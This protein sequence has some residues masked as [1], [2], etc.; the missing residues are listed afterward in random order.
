MGIR[1]IQGGSGNWKVR[2]DRSVKKGW[3]RI[4]AMGEDEGLVGQVDRRR[5]E[6][7]S[8]FIPP[9]KTKPLFF[10]YTPKKGKSLFWTVD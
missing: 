10:N 7:R 5:G 9:K 1:D 2:G 8:F 6:F 4:G 3:G